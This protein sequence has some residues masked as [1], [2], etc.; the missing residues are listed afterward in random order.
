MKISFI[1]WLIY[2]K[3][4]INQINSEFTCCFI[5]F[6]Q[7]QFISAAGFISRFLL[8]IAFYFTRHDV[9][10][11]YPLN[12]NSLLYCTHCRE[13]LNTNI[14]KKT[15]EMEKF[16]LNN[17]FISSLYSSCYNIASSH[18]SWIFIAVE[19]NGKRREHLVEMINFFHT[20]YF[21]A[22]VEIL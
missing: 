12:K 21:G 4:S 3:L 11:I 9:F 5:E 10:Y 14:R 13:E 16:C 6:I 22:E 2:W 20:P 15:R 18:F 7:C 17:N 19:L 8:F 1:L